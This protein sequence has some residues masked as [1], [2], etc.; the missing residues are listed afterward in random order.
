MLR[1]AVGCWSYS[2]IDC[3]IAVAC[4][5]YSYPLSRLQFAA[6]YA[7]VYVAPTCMITCIVTYGTKMGVWAAAMP[8]SR[9]P[10]K[11]KACK[12]ERQFLPSRRV[13]LPFFFILQFVAISRSRVR[14][15][16]FFSKS[17]AP[18][19]FRGDGVRERER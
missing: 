3:C 6:S 13:S 4:I 17:D 8:L 15:D 11:P 18:H 1:R 5:V 12:I 2:T 16:I 10:N 9:P 14:Y 19:V 7:R